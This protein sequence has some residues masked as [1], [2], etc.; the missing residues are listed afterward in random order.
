MGVLEVRTCESYSY[1][2]ILTFPF[3]HRTDGL[4]GSQERH[5]PSPDQVCSKLHVEKIGFH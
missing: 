5:S 3:S 2:N 1:C 4:A